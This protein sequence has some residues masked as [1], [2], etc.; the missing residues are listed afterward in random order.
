MPKKT[1]QDM[2]YAEIKEMHAKLDKVL[3][4][5]IPEM[6]GDIKVLNVK[7]GI[8]GALSGLIGGVAVA[9]GFAR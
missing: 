1:I 2:M 6:K 5:E 4:Q 9:F 3:T 8:W 7:A